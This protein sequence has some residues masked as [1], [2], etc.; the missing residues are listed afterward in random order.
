MN[1]KPYP[2]LIWF[3]VIVGCLS[4]VHAQNITNY[5]FS[6]TQ[7]SF[8]P[9][10]GGIAPSLTYGDYDEGYYVNIPLGFDF[11]YQGEL[12]TQVHASTNGF[13]GLGTFYPSQ[14]LNSATNNLSSV[15]SFA[16]SRPL[17]APLW[18]NLDMDSS[19]GAKFSY[20][21]IG[22]QPNRVFTAEWL[23]AEWN[24]FANAP[25]VSFQV[26][27]YESTGVIEYIYNQEAASAFSPTASIGIT[28]ATSNM[29]LSLNNS[30]INPTVSS[31]VSYNGINTKPASGQLYRFTPPVP[32]SVASATVS[33]IEPTRMLVSWSAATGAVKYAVY[34]SL[35][36]VNFAY[37]G[38]SSS[39]S[40]SVGSLTPNTLYYIRIYALSEGALSVSPATTSGTTV[41]GA[42]SGTFSIPGSFATITQA[43]DSIK[44]VGIGGP[45]I[46]ELQSNYT[47]ANE[48]FPIIFSD[49]L[50]SSQNA[51]ITLRP[52]S[53]VT[54]L[55]IESPQSAIASIAFIRARYI[56]IDGRA[57]G[58]G[59]GKDLTIKANINT[60][61]ISFIHQGGDHVVINAVRVNAVAGNSYVYQYIDVSNYYYYYYNSPLTLENYITISDCEIGDSN[62][63]GYC[64]IYSGYN[65]LNNSR[66]TIMIKNNHIFNIGM[67]N[68]YGYAYAIYA[69]YN[70]LA[71][72]TWYIE[73]NHIYNLIPLSAT[74]S[75]SVFYA[76]YTSLSNA[77][78][79]NN[80]IGGSGPYCSGSA[81]ETGPASSDNDFYGIYCAGNNTASVASIQGNKIA[82]FFWPGVSTTPWT[83]IYTSVAEA[84][85]GDT[86]GNVIGDTL[87]N[88]NIYILSQVNSSTPV[89]YG[90]N[91]FNSI[92]AKIANNGIYGISA[93][94]TNNTY[95]CSFTG[96][97]AR[98]NSDLTISN[99]TIG[100]PTQLNSVRT[101][102]TATNS[103][104]QLF[105]IT[106]NNTT[107]GRSSIIG[108]GIYNLS[109]NNASSSL[110]GNTAGINLNINYDAL[111]TD[112]IV[113]KISSA[114]NNP[115]VS[116]NTALCGIYAGITSGKTNISRNRVYGLQSTSLTNGGRV[117]GIHVN[118]I[119]GEFIDVNANHVHS[120]T[121]ATNAVTAGISAIYLQDGN[122]N[123]YNNMVRL[124]ID[125]NGAAM[126]KSCV[127]AGIQ[128][129]TSYFAN[130]HH[131]TVY[132]GGTSSGTTNVNTFAFRKSNDG[133]DELLNN[134]FV[135]VRTNATTGGKHYAVS[136]NSSNAI[137]SNN[138]LLQSGGGTYGRLFQLG[139]IDYNNRT[140][141]FTQTGFDD[142][143]D[144]TIV[145]FV[146]AT[147]NA[148]SVNLRLN[149]ALPSKA[150][151]N[152]ASSF[153]N[154][155]IDGQIRSA[156]S[157][158][159]IGAYAGNFPR[160][161]INPVPVVWAWIKGTVNG[162]DGQVNWKVAS[163]LNNRVFWVQRSFDGITFKTI[164][165]VKGA[166]TTGSAIIYS[167]T[168][169]GV[170]SDVCKLVYY[171]VVQEDFDGKQ[172]ISDVVTLRTD[173]VGVE[174]VVL[175]PNPARNE[176]TVGLSAIPAGNV[177]IVIRNTAGVVV[178][179][180]N[181]Q[182][183][184]QSVNTAD[185]S[186][187]VY[188]V[189]I[190]G[191]GQAPVIKKL[192]IE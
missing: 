3:A 78:I 7:S 51:P 23:N 181:A 119:S 174:E 4:V 105:G 70:Y 183:Q 32:G 53:G 154:E 100:Y 69:G 121:V 122:V 150:E 145:T 159:D 46:L 12:V 140:T 38:G 65:Y 176:V 189:S 30:G 141:W 34:Y 142:N 72:S 97:F 179:Q 16:T 75:S 113:Y 44:R 90:I 14:N 20:Q 55:V 187:G 185:L 136:Y 45:V 61:A 17:V 5:S 79:K 29:Y 182:A 81:F 111:V 28:S 93:G 76:I 48:R 128:K 144:T 186:A 43:L 180:I 6:S 47:C 152:G 117:M 177:E 22:V 49:T 89:A 39:L 103:A 11:W 170:F 21:T 10:T 172:S 36:N 125:E 85:I 50:G 31:T 88:T 112:N 83:G 129:A 143:S 98:N 116:G 169:A 106:V 132:I 164:G 175:W 60:R 26:R 184:T 42:L 35:D 162:Q 13:L 91:V 167:Y 66:T 102:S 126:N 192:V 156:L 18:D 27:L 109:N 1:K 99:N 148:A 151:G 166:G 74:Y 56:T 104:Q 110:Q 120:F 62:I 124:G 19:T 191:S 25:T 157:P 9:I 134:I 95:P 160:I 147:G 178:K 158:V 24:W 173:V 161:N 190:K 2:V 73:D 130:V 127:I 87:S 71:N 135:N 155:D 59:S 37:A 64:G 171:R 107:I 52:A 139:S 188:L 86:T 40:L 146:N 138:N 133:S 77:V 149:G 115:S 67:T 41:N 118:S 108:N 58:T 131:N 114:S 92:N 68:G 123:V 54:G 94:G 80:F 137:Y 63:V 153:V 168:D 101:F 165:E 82:N 8:T 57:G 15:V 163:Q 84:H 33:N 96:I